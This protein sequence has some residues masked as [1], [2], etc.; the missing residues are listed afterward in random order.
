MGNFDDFTVKIKIRSFK[1]LKAIEKIFEGNPYKPT[2]KE[3]INRLIVDIAGFF[4]N[5]A[6][7]INDWL[8]WKTCR[9]DDMFDVWELRLYGDNQ[10]KDDKPCQ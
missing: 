4:L 5:M 10:M 8:F 7:K 6:K 1:D 9:I 3:K 2:P